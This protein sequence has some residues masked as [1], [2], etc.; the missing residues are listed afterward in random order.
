V[1]QEIVLRCRQGSHLVFC[2]A[3][4]QAEVLADQ[5]HAIAALEKWPVDHTFSITAQFRKIYA[6]KQ[7]YP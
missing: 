6:I 7:S 2:N 4:A 1:A 3:R 5:L